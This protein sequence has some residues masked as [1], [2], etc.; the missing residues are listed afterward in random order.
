MNNISLSIF[1]Y[2]VSEPYSVLFSNATCI[3]F[4]RRAAPI[5]A[6]DASTIGLVEV[7][8]WFLQVK[9]PEYCS[10]PD[11]FLDFYKCPLLLR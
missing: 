9:I 7:Y 8:N 2:R 10:F 1:E 4:W 5:P 3:S 11:L 6:V